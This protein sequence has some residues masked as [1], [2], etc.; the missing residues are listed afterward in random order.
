[1]GASWAGHSFELLWSA[2]GSGQKTEFIFPMA[3]APWLHCDSTKQDRQHYRCDARNIRLC[4]ITHPKAYGRLLNRLAQHFR[5]Q[6]FF[7]LTAQASAQDRNEK[8]LK[9]V[10]LPSNT[11]PDQAPEGKTLENRDTD[12][13]PLSI[14]P[15]PEGQR[16][17]P[18]QADRE[19]I[20]RV[21][22][23]VG[24]RGYRSSTR[25]GSVA[26]LGNTKED[27]CYRNDSMKY[28]ST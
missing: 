6:I 14:Q 24:S 16:P 20:L 28:V 5:V 21:L 10:R 4:P 19:K 23:T 2:F 12:H 22:L 3:V 9:P 18:L 7:F 25:V 13:R 26:P 15:Q 1:M 27:D 8:S 17:P 11:H